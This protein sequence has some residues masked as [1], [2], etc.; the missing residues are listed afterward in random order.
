MT[1]EYQVGG[2]L[3]ADAP[4]YVTRQA[5][6]ELYRALIAGEFCYVLQPRQVGKS[7]IGVRM[8][9][10]LKADGIA[11]ASI[12]LSRLGT[13]EASNAEDKWYA[14]IIRRLVD[15]FNLDHSARK[16]WWS[17]HDDIS[18]IDRFN[19][20]IDEVLLPKTD[21]K[22][23]L[24]I[25]I[26][27]I[28][29]VLGLNF[30]RDDF[31]AAIRS[32]YNLRSEYPA[33]KRLT[34]CLLGVA[35]PQDLI[36]HPATSPFNIGR[37]IHLRGLQWSEAGHLAQGLKNAD[38][39]EV[40]LQ[41]ILEW[42][43]GQPFLTQKL[44]R[45]VETENR[46][47]AGE[48]GER[49]A[50]LVEGQIIENWEYQDE[51]VHLRTVRDRILG[52]VKVGDLNLNTD[53]TIRSLSLYQKVF[54]ND[55]KVPDYMS[56]ESFRLQ[57]SGV[58]INQQGKL[59]VANPIYRAIFNQK[60]VETQLNDLRPYS[61]PLIAWFKSKCQDDTYLLRGQKLQE[62]SNWAEGRSLADEDYQF[63]NASLKAEKDAELAQKDAELNEKEERL[64]EAEENVEKTNLQLQS[65]TAD[66]ERIAV[67]RESKR[68]AFA[69]GGTVF[70]GLAVASLVG[71]VASSLLDEWQ[72]SG[73]CLPNLIRAG[74]TC[75]VPLPEEK[76]SS[77]KRSLF[78]SQVE[79]EQTQG[80]K[81][82]S[83]E[84]YPEAQRWF[85]SAVSK[86]PREPE[87][88]IY[89]NNSLARQKGNPY[90]L[91]VSLPTDNSPDSAKE[92]LRGI[93]D[94]QTKF[95]SDSQNSRRVEVLLVNDSSSPKLAA[96]IAKQLSDNPQV[97]GVIGH[98]S[99]DASAAALPEYEK[100][101][102]AMVAPTS[103]STALKGNVFF[104]AIP[105]DQASSRALAKYMFDQK[106]QKIALF[107]DQSSYGT[108]ISQSFEAW[109]GGSILNKVDFQN[110]AQ[111]SFAIFD[112]QSQQVQALV[113]FPSVE[114]VPGA[115]AIAR[116]N[117]G[118]L[119]LYGGDSLYHPS[120][121][122]DGG[123]AVNGM[124]LVVPWFASPEPR[125]Y[126]K[127][128]DGRWN[129]Q[130]SWRTASSYDATQALLATL[131]GNVTR[132]QV[133]QRLR[134]VSL[135]ATETSG[136]PLRFDPNGERVSSPRLVEVSENAANKPAG[137]R[138]GFRLVK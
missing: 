80:M 95:N 77:G 126:A 49:V 44:C 101:G 136:D 68:K 107:S 105:S 38:N 52:Q 66:R 110:I 28:D 39:S 22:Q 30:S 1:F 2:S 98:N 31:F 99:S 119:K 51:P 61:Q 102:L 67:E 93:A 35:T 43:G 87:P 56:H 25:F 27:E 45:L 42:T 121:L 72:K 117:A 86:Y 69:R 114:N 6:D 19:T 75:N 111:F 85:E 8:R 92:M 82:F 96:V 89:L 130:V 10:R 127:E 40:V 20:F 137:S 79:D 108:S 57:L 15:E 29:S 36:Q 131:F 9:S 58:L 16:K 88:Q 32:Y 83:L 132:A 59:R 41:K 124:V 74:R 73:P 81:A 100:A 5:D 18:S 4:S 65:I 11:C 138:F 125:N 113:L 116:N 37:S 54:Q 97:L 24:V 3:S 109:F 76:F 106:S 70:L 104:R 7:S 63:L 34:F 91:A 112:T 46:I 128:A 13:G 115:I 55:D 17:E 134:S 103:T 133:L 50:H 47:S 78:L 12:D 48:E 14:G 123:E 33:Y 21:Q 71:I 84:N 62:A 120:I 118:K 90:I 64:E 122:T 53:D 60:W 26:D 135:P 94:A 129:G 23:K